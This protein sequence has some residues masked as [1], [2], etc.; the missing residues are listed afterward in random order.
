MKTKAGQV[1]IS[2]VIP[3]LKPPVELVGDLHKQTFKDF[4]IVIGGG[5]SIPKGLND[6]IRRAR[7]RKIIF[8]ESDVRVLDRRWLERMNALL[9]AHDIVKA[10]QVILQDPLPESYNN[11]G[12]S[13][14][15]AKETLFNESYRNSEDVEWFEHLRSKGYK[16]VRARGPVVWHFKK[17]NVHKLVSWSFEMGVAFSRIAL[18]YKNPEINFKRMFLSKAYT[19]GGEFLMLCGEIWGIFVSV[20]KG[21]VKKH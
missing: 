16:V 18:S 14:R 17:V 7:G 20:F 1:E 3:A 19:F 10:D 4:E 21:E 5:D 12:I 2:I 13:S 15:I 9:N 8:L 11:L 6:G